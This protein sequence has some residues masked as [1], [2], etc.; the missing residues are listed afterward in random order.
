MQQYYELLRKILNK[1]TQSDDRTGTGTLHLFGEHLSFD[2]NDG[3]P[4]LTGKFT[5]FKMVAA[6]L[7]WM[8]SG[9][10]NNEDLR[11]LNESD[12]ATIWE[13]WAS[14]DEL[15]PIYG[16][17]WRKWGSDGESSGIDQ[18][19][20]LIAGLKSRPFSRRHIVSAWN[21]A[22]L[23]DEELSPQENV[24]NYQMALAPCHAFAQFG[25]RTLSLAERGIH[26]TVDIQPSEYYEDSYHRVLDVHSVPRYAVSCHLYCRSQDC[27]L[28]TPYN[29]ASYALLVHIIAK[30]T[31]MV[32]DHLYISMGDSHI[33]LNHIE[34]TK[35]L[36]ARDLSLFPLPTLELTSEIKSIADITLKSF[37]LIGY[38]SHQAIYA[39]ISV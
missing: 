25:V 7:L 35:E 13:E 1:G 21:V 17:Q 32:P 34:Q 39:P 23:P 15:G 27:F 24:D 16:H 4:L 38:E 8:L 9:S 3:F 12:R 22:D 36:L 19:A 33:Y 11:K 26:C 31:G 29:I 18:I 20:R 37:S 2:L 5:S 6:E 28:G 30:L 14:D 10:T